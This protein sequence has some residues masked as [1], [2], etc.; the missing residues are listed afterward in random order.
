[1]QKACHTERP[2]AQYTHLRSRPGVRARQKEERC[3]TATRDPR[4]RAVGDRHV[5]VRN[6]GGR[7]NQRLATLSIY[8]SG[9]NMSLGLQDCLILWQLRP[10]GSNGP[11]RRPQGRRI[12]AL[13]CR[14]EEDV[15][16]IY[17][18][19]AGGRSDTE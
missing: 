6:E 4:H 5:I 11:N 1:M 17:S 10:V 16:N 2:C 7:A 12:T 19:G 9:S 13:T 8:V 3:A 15:G 18:E 14:A